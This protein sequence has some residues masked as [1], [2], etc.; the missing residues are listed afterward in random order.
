MASFSPREEIKKKQLKDVESKHSLEIDRENR[1]MPELKPDKALV[2]IVCPPM[3]ARYTGHGE[4]VKFHANNQVVAVHKMGAYS[5]VYLDPGDYRLASQSRRNAFAMSIRLEAGK[6][7]YF[8][9]DVSYGGD[10]S[11]ARHSKELAMYELSGTYY[12]NWK[13]K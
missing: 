3:A 8:Q 9:Q 13:R 7:Y 12:A 1:P 2:V 4:Q 10:T 5:F 11:L 6:E